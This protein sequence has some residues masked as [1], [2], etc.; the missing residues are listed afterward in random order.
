MVFHGYTVI[1]DLGIGYWVKD[2]GKAEIVSCFTYYCHMGYVTS[3]GGKIRALNGNNSYG[4]YGAVSTGYNV[5]EVT[6]DGTV[7]GDQLTYSNESLSGSFE[8]G[9]IITGSISGATGTVTDF[10]PTANKVYY[11]RT[12]VAPFQNNETISVVAGASAAITSSGV[13][14][15]NGFILVLSG[16]SEEPK[17]GASI[18]FTSGDTTTYVIQSV[19]EYNLGQAI[20]VL[21][22]EKSVT[23][24]DGTGFKIR[25]EFSN[26]RLT[27]H[28]F[29]NVGT[30]G[31]T[32]TNYP[33]KPLQA[34][35][36]GNEV[37]EQFPARVFYVSTDQDGNFRVGEYFR[38]DQATGR[39][40]LNASAFDLLAPKSVK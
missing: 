12:S 28:D 31:I 19:S 9:D 2:N 3:G 34:P 5:D 15:Q 16:L 26:I 39:A 37:I 33:D 14:G 22:G 17:P 32:T 8:S 11:K 23:S 35:S 4:T 18:E 38:V 36:Q 29:L 30:G 7:Y 10:Q 27:G 25:Y 40:T 21:A 24:G 20:I 1:S 6:L 13:S